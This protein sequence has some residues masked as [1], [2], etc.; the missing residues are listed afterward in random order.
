M[1]SSSLP[2][3]LFFGQAFVGKTWSFK[4]L[5]DEPLDHVMKHTSTAENVEMTVSDFNNVEHKIILSDTA[6][7]DHYYELIK[8]L[9][10][11]ANIIIGVYAVDD[12]SSLS[13]LNERLKYMSNEV[14]FSQ[15]GFLMLGN[16][17]DLIQDDAY[18]DHIFVDTQS[19]KDILN[20]FDFK[21]KEFIEVSAKTGEHFTDVNKILG[22]MI[23]KIDILDKPIILTTNKNGCC[24]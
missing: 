2:R 23:S 15:I 10:H 13:T 9:F 22:D 5:L 6:G 20:S 8:P 17:I 14:D 24:H 4:R 21:F 19:A 11:N 7:E 16:K 18:K 3:V 12:P 1:I